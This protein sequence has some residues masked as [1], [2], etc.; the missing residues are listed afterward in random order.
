MF[1]DLVCEHFDFVPT[2]IKDRVALME[3]EVDRNTNMLRCLVRDK[4]YHRNSLDEFFDERRLSIFHFLLPFLSGF[5]FSSS[6]LSNGEPML[7]IDM[8]NTIIHFK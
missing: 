8:N 1:L 6:H 3:H 7:T 5:G 4:T 2:Q